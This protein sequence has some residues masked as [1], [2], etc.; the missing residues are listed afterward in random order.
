MKHVILAR[1]D[2]TIGMFRGQWCVPIAFEEPFEAMDQINPLAVRTVC[3]IHFYSGDTIEDAIYMAA[4]MHKTDRHSDDVTAYEC[5]PVG[6]IDT[7]GTI[8]GARV[9]I[10]HDRPHEL[11]VLTLEQYRAAGLAADRMSKYPKPLVFRQTDCPEII[12]MNARNAI[13]NALIDEWCEDLGD[14]YVPHKCI[15]TIRKA[16]MGKPAATIEAKPQGESR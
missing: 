1:S 13:R 7:D 12:T 5:T 4:F 10:I 6:E 15:E 14:V 2:Q 9:V 3:A 8:D 16:A 11:P